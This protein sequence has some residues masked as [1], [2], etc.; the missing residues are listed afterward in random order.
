MMTSDLYF[1]PLAN[2][3][4]GMYGLFV[5]EIGDDLSLC[6]Y[7]DV[8]A[9]LP[10]TALAGGIGG[11]CFWLTIFPADV[12]KSRIQVLS[13]DGSNHTFRSVSKHIFKNEGM[14]FIYLY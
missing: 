3:F 14:S 1:K 13:I 2:Y 8:I 9:G 11:C 12:V 5:I 7:D 6:C 4:L 10:R